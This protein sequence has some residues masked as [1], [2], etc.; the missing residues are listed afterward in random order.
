MKLL[1]ENAYYYN[2]EGS[3]IY[4]LAQEL[5]VR[6]PLVSVNDAHGLTKLP[7]I[8]QSAVEEGRCCGA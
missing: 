4:E 1:W 8:R 7:D 5:E 6:E 2:E 3:D